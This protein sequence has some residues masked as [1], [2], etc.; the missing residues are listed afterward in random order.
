M[1]GL[2]ALPNLKTV[3]RYENSDLVSVNMGKSVVTLNKPIYL[4][5]AILDIS[6]TLMYEFHYNYIKRKY[7]PRAR[8]LFT[9]T[10]SLCYII[11]TEDFFIDIKE[12]VPK[13]F[14]TSDY[15]SD[16]PA[17]L[18]LMNKKEIGFFK[19][20]CKS[21][22]MTEFVGLRPKLYAGKVQ[23]SD[24]NKKCKGGKKAIVKKELAF[25]DY[26]KCLFGN[27]TV[28]AKFNIFRALTITL[29]PKRLQK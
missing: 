24:D 27:K 26:K 12:D 5:Q 22:Q 21:K 29:Q 18:P 10:D 19:D 25:E 7:G 13:W 28:Y 3:F 16:H 8:L 2:I 17:G 4:G 15:P 6:K 9:D 1:L 11:E 23:Y 14:D 20:E